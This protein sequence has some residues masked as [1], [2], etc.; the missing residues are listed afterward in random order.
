MQVDVGRQ[1]KKNICD[2]VLGTQK[3]LQ[4]LAR[5]EEVFAWEFMN[6]MSSPS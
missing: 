2:E 3:Q 4:V 5:T 6:I 1:R